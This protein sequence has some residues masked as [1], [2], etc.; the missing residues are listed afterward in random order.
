MQLRRNLERPTAKA[1]ARSLSGLFAMAGLLLLVTASSPFAQAPPSSLQNA[2]EAEKK[3]AEREADLSS[4]L[5][6][7]DAVV[8]PDSLRVMPKPLSQWLKVACTAKAHIFVGA[9]PFVAVGLLGA[10]FIIAG[11][12]TKA[13][14]YNYIRNVSFPESGTE[15]M[16]QALIDTKSVA[17]RTQVKGIVSAFRV[18]TNGGCIVD[19][20][21]TE[22]VT[23]EKAYH[24]KSVRGGLFPLAMIVPRDEAIRRIV[25]GR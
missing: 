24:A 14:G 2:A 15:N 18:E 11:H 1:R 19:A 21:I 10:N 20:A 25:E 3:L 6:S 8:P 7:C 9:E 23:G 12:C 16:M 17:I 13:D 5:V 22:L 4:L